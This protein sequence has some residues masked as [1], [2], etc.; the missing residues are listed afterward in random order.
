MALIEIANETRCL[1]CVY[2]KW[3]LLAAGHTF[4]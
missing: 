3:L 4:Y 1:Y 2:K